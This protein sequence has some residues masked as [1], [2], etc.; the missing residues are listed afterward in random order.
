M[1]FRNCHGCSLGWREPSSD[2]TRARRRASPPP[3]SRSAA[4][5]PT[6]RRVERIA[7]G[8][9][10][11]LPLVVRITPCVFP[12]RLTCLAPLDRLARLALVALLA[13]LLCPPCR[14]SQAPPAGP[15]AAAPPLAPPVAAPPT[16]SPA[17]PPPQKTAATQGAVSRGGRARDE[18]DRLKVA[19]ERQWAAVG[20]SGQSGI[21]VGN[22]REMRGDERRVGGNGRRMGGMEGNGEEW[23][24]MEEN[25]GEQE[26]NG[27]EWEV[28][29]EKWEG[30]GGE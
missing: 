30:N 24:R 14:S 8:G 4:L 28:N 19:D 16:V 26:G 1:N 7:R 21:W 10:Q 2:H 15:P 12:S 20:G 13:L 27:G 18:E 29:G 23:G 22:G 9:Q 6:A 17:A 11:H 5:R 25:E 3:R